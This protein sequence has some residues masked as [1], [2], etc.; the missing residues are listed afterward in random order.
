PHSE[1]PLHRLYSTSLSSTISP[2][3]LTAR[4]HPPPF[5]PLPPPRLPFPRLPF[6]RF[7]PFPRPASL[8][9]QIHP[10][11]LYPSPP[12]RLPFPRLTI[13]RLLCPRLAFRI[14]FQLPIRISSLLLLIIVPRSMMSPR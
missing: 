3:P 7:F 11:P 13:P 4:I 2:A 9:A 6:P 10:P 1:L 8:T 12:P 5:Y 14:S